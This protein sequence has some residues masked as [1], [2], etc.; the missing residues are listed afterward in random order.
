MWPVLGWPLPMCTFLYG[1][2]NCT[3]ARLTKAVVSGR[4]GK[5][6][7]VKMSGLSQRWLRFR[8]SVRPDVKLRKWCR[9]KSIKIFRSASATC[10]RFTLFSVLLFLNQHLQINSLY[11][12][13]EI[14]N[15]MKSYCMPH[16]WP[17]LSWPSVITY[18]QYFRNIE[19][20]HYSTM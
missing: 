18:L 9:L 17:L 15:F 11:I 19:Q 20:H 8:C 4:L 2:L 1:T 14:I 7:E 6:H 5:C 13:N 10:L 12:N 3:F 16:K